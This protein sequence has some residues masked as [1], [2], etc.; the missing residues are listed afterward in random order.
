MNNFELIDDFLTNRL[1]E[2][3][4]AAFEKELETNAPLKAEVALQKLA[5]EGVKKARAAELKAMLNNVPMG[6]SVSMEW[7]ALKIAA[8]IVGAGILV[9]GLT[10]YFKSDQ[11]LNPTNFS[12]SMEDSLKQP[13]N[14]TNESEETPS[15]PQQETVSPAEDSKEEPKKEAVKEKA[16]QKGVEKK[17]NNKSAEAVKPKIEVI[18][19]TQEL[20]ENSK[21][22]KNTT[23]ENKKALVSVSHISVETDATNKKYGFHYQFSQGKLHL[24]GNFDKGLYEIL[25]V[26]GDSHAVFMYYKEL[27][28]LLDEKQSAITL[29]EPIKDK[30]LLSKLKE[31]RGR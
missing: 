23:G 14:K 29:L 28:Y 12:S 5:I 17:T 19:P 20:A 11:T 21:T 15:Q 30:T 16:E 4:K 31:Y 3:E 10:F 18:D 6:A 25:E 24:Y 9:A 26:N 2:P 8:G 22:E 27:Y 1:G 7:S 13:E